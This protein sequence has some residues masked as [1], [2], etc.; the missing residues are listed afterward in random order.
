MLTRGKWLLSVGLAAAA[1][2]ALA[3]GVSPGTLLLFGAALLCPAA[4]FFGMHGTG[5]R[6]EAGCCGGHSAR[7]EPHEPADTRGAA[8]VAPV[9]ERRKAA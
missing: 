7:H 1:V 4:M 2:A 5:G 9:G 8:E 6:H 3:L